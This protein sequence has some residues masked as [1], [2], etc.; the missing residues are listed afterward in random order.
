MPPD[1][2]HAGRSTPKAERHREGN[3][4]EEE[5][6]VIDH[7]A[8]VDR[9]REAASVRRRREEL[10]RRVTQAPLR[11]SSRVV[12]VLPVQTREHLRLSVR[13]GVLAVQSLV[14][15]LGSAGMRLSDRLF[16]EPPTPTASAPVAA[17]AVSAATA[18]APSP[19]TSADRDARSGG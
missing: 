14:D 10:R 15:A 16:T 19:T 11:L 1:A 9:E 12:G 5:L 18:A 17:E 4:D 3:M 13:E 2:A 6:D 8:A 7:R